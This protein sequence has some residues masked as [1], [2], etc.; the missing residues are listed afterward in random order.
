MKQSEH[1]EAEKQKFEQTEKVLMNTSLIL[2]WIFEVIPQ[3]YGKERNKKR[4]FNRPL[5]GRMFNPFAWGANKRFNPCIYWVLHICACK[6]MERRPA[7]QQVRK[8]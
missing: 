8:T 5:F 2:I 7:C 6:S 3:H 1:L 4:K